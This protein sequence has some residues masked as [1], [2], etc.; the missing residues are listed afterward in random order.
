MGSDGMTLDSQGNLYLTG[1][2]VTIFNQK[3]EKLRTS[4]FLKNGHP[5]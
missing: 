5:M 4:Q 3:G 2:G 1:K